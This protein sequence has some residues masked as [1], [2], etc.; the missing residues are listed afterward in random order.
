MTGRVVV[1][2][3]FVMCAR[4]TNMQSDERG[5]QRVKERMATASLLEAMRSPA[6]MLVS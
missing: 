1:L 6:I 3:Y 5:I 2:H 4:P